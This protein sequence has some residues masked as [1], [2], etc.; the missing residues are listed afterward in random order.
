MK[1]NCSIFISYARLDQQKVS[2]FVDRLE[3][4]GFDVWVDYQR[5][6]P[7]QNWNFEIE[8]ALGKATFVVSFVSKLSYDR[9]GYLQRE[10]RLALDKL[11]E[12]LIDDIYLI[13]VLLD[14]EVQIPEQLKHLHCIRASN[15]DCYAQIVDAV[16][17]QLERLGLE[18]QKIQKQEQV[19]WKYQIK[20]EEWDG[21]PGYEVEL[22]FFEFISDRYPCVHEI[23]EYIKGILLPTLFNHRK[24][25]FSQSPEFFDYSHEKF[26]RTN[27]FDAQCREPIIVGKTISIQYDVHWYGAGAAHPNYH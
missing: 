7:G 21:I 26:R 8:R 5:L 13:P 23:G 18:Q 24:F 17:Y 4:Q 27:I 20:R 19:Y 14:D 22:Q 12:K 6:K 11:T 25:K 15:P 1:D 2:L 10:L 3:E 9:R 16:N